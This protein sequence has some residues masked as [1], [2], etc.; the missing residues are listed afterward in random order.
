M[1]F[2]TRCPP[3]RAGR[4]NTELLKRHR[5]AARGW[6]LRGGDVGV[7]EPTLQ[8]GVGGGC[9]AHLLT[10]ENNPALPSNG[11]VGLDA[12]YPLCSL[13]VITALPSQVCRGEK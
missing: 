9:A 8:P 1:A 5:A 6:E 13:G 11:C 2:N 3:R 7:G 10:L 12:R 4:I